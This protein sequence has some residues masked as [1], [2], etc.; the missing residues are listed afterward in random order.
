MIIVD[1]VL[2]KVTDIKSTQ[3]ELLDE[4]VTLYKF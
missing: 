4:K 1:G 2:P 3:T